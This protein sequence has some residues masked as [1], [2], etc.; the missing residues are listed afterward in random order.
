MQR[1]HQLKFKHKQ[2]RRAAEQ[3]KAAAK[4]TGSG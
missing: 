2:E 1:L 4:E 3:A